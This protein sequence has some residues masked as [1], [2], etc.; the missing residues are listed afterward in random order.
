MSEVLEEVRE[1]VNAIENAITCVEASDTPILDLVPWG[2]AVRD[3]INMAFA[4]HRGI[5]S[6]A[7]LQSVPE[8]VRPRIMG[9]ILSARTDLMPFTPLPKACL[10]AVSYAIMQSYYVAYKAAMVMGSNRFTVG[11]VRI[12]SILSRVKTKDGMYLDKESIIGLLRELRDLVTSAFV[13][14]YGATSR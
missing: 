4:R 8:P 3:V 9:S 12:V 1:A 5:I 7:I 14:I 10:D 13:V 11:I 6:A 2:R